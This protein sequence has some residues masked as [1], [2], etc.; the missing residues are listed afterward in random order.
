MK[1]VKKIGNV[2][3]IIKQL[4][5]PELTQR[6]VLI[7][8]VILKVVNVF[9]ML[10]KEVET[11]E[12]ILKYPITGL[13]FLG[14]RSRCVFFLFLLLSTMKNFENGVYKTNTS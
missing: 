12:N 14:K 11:W 2:M 1:T 13:P 9:H 5:N 10:R 4:T 6:L 8:K 3:R 7:D